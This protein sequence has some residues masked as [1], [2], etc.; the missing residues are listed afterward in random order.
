MGGRSGGE[1]HDELTTLIIDILLQGRLGQAL[2]EK[3]AGNPRTNLIIHHGVANVV[4]QTAKVI[5]VLGA[6]EEPRDLASPFQWNEVLKN[7]IQFPTRLWT[8][9]RAFDS[10]GVGYRLRISLLSSSL[11]SPLGIGTLND[12]ASPSTRD[13]NDSIVWRHSTVFWDRY[14]YH[15]R[16]DLKEMD[17][18]S[19]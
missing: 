13:I 19:Q 7:T 11:T 16:Q 9:D 15:G 18:T 6:V 12:S 8:S 1:T 10:E 2:D 5:H 4:D 17:R 3:G 14:K